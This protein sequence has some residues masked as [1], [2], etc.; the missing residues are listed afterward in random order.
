[1]YRYCCHIFIYSYAANGFYP[2][3]LEYLKE[4]YH[5]SYDTDKYFVD[6]QALGE[7]IFPDITIIEKQEES[8]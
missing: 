2:E 4:H 6:Y 1:M 5:I 7:N 8:P 3:S